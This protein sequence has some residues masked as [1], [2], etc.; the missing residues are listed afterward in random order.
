MWLVHNPMC[1]ATTA[2]EA[3]GM[4]QRAREVGLDLVMQVIV[5]VAMT[6]PEARVRRA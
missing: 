6:T 4:W 2:T 5:V 1:K 3:L